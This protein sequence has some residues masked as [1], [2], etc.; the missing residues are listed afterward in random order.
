LELLEDPALEQ[1]EWKIQRIA[2]FLMA[3]FVALALLGFF[4][5]GPLSSRVVTS[6]DG[7]FKLEYNRFERFQAPSTLRLQLRANGQ[8]TARVWISRKFM[9]NVKVDSMVPAAERVEMR[10][11]G[12]V[13]TFSVPRSESSSIVFHLETEEMGGRPIRI[14]VDDGPPLDAPHWVYP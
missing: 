10:D 8:P 3:L 12:F 1:R 9:E 2:W 7:R 14:K 5:A 4:G 6:S 11:D 13:Y